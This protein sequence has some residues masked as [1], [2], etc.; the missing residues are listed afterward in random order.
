DI[1]LS[2]TGGGA[3]GVRVYR[4][5]ACFLADT[6][7]AFG[8]IDTGAHSAGCATNANDQ[9][10][11]RTL[12]WSA[13]SSGAHVM[14]GGY[15][16][17]WTPIRN[18]V[19]LPDTC[20]CS[21]TQPSA[22]A[23]NWD[24]TITAGTSQT[25]SHR[26]AFTGSTTPTA[27][28]TATGTATATATSAPVSSATSTT[29]PLPIATTTATSTTSPTTTPTTSPTATRT[30]TPTPTNTPTPMPTSTNTATAT[31]TP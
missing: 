17:V 26:T 7:D 25:F 3:L 1:S 2:N 18:E 24:A 29:T 9:P 30:S 27:T 6:W 20:E 11:G 31:N 13:I 8:V 5:G 22:A 12:T 14:E 19:N 16:N 28:P 10:P 4:I 15:E 23:L 21:T